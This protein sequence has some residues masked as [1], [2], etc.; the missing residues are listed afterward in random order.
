MVKAPTWTKP[1]LQQP[2][3]QEEELL[4]QLRNERT[5][6]E[7]RLAP[8]KEQMA[9][10]EADMAGIQSPAAPTPQAIPQFQGREL[11]GQELNQFMG[12]AMA[13]A[14]L[15]TK[16]V[17]GDAAMGVNAAAAAIN[18]FNEGNLAQTKVD[19]QNF[20]TKM[21]AVVQSNK[22]MLDEYT[23][24]LNDRKMTL[25]QKMQQYNV[26][27]H[28]YQDEMAMAAIKRGDIRFELDRLDKIRQANNQ[29]EIMSARIGATMEA[30]WARTQGALMGM[31]GRIDA[32]DRATAQ[33]ADAV[34]AKGSTAPQ[35]PLPAK[36][37]EDLSGREMVVGLMD[38]LI[39]R[40]EQAIAEGRGF[41]G[42]GF[43][44]AGNLIVRGG[45]ALGQN[46]PEALFFS[47]LETVAQPARHALFGAT[48]TGGEAQS[49]RTGFVGA[50]DHPQTLLSVLKQKRDLYARMADAQRNNYRRLGFA[51]DGAQPAPNAAT[52][53]GIIQ[54]M[55][56]AG[57]N[58][59]PAGSR[60]RDPMGNVR[61]KR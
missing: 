19:I 7:G 58:A 33:R 45:R 5:L 2:G 57:Y 9:G 21:N 14:A 10:L 3:L 22:Q 52:E 36:A 16:A 35:R 12:I 18:G 15:G 32:M 24:V 50:G 51:V 41:G 1:D 31:Q 23:R 43:D 17:R 56:D 42:Y 6:T 61:T 25:Q 55:D 20:N 46:T 60:Y 37:A 4:T 47:D 54:I 39:K 11:D 26:L 44:A 34:A 48:L 59:L 49:W 27:A 8:I 40:Q 53:D 30:Q 28:K 29:A 13:L 38:D